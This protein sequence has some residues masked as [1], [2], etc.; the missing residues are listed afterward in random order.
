MKPEDLCLMNESGEVVEVGNM[1]TVNPAGF[2][3]HNAIHK[4]RP[5]VIAAVHCHSVPSKAFASLGCELEPIT[6]DSCR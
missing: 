5:D 6:Q 3:I 4:A 2:A 1:H